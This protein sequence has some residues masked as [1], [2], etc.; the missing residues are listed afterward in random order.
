MSFSFADSLIWAHKYST[1]EL[2]SI[3]LTESELSARHLRY[4]PTY[5]AVIFLPTKG[6]TILSRATV[7]V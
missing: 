7:T 5:H 4:K 6:D 3:H 2:W 1:V